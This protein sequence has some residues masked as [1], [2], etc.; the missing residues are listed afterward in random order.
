MLEAQ[1]FTLW[2]GIRTSA[3]HYMCD[4]HA[5]VPA[6]MPR[7]ND[8]RI[9]PRSTFHQGLLMSLDNAGGLPTAYVY[10]GPVAAVWGWVVASLANVLVGLSMAEIASSYPVAGGPYFW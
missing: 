9:H 1:A 6:C 10:G 8:T 5:C 4:L 7:Q 2:M 3:C